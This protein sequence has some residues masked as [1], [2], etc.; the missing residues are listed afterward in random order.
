MR[1]WDY[2]RVSFAHSIRGPAEKVTEGPG[3]LDHFLRPDGVAVVGASTNPSKLGYGIARNLVEGGYP[4]YVAL[5]NAKGGV[6]FD[7]PLYDSI[8]AVPRHVD[9]AVILVPA[10][11]VPEV[12]EEVGTCRIPAAIIASGGFGEQG[13]DGTLLEQRCLAIARRYGIRLLGPNCIGILDTHLPLDTTFL[14][15]PGPPKGEIAFVSQ[16]GA[17]CAIV[18][19]WAKSLDLGISKLISLGNQLDITETDVLGPI[20]RDP[21]SAVVTLYLEGVDDGRRFVRELRSLSQ[22]KP[23]IVLKVGR[24]DDGR[25]AVSSHTGAMAGS[26]AGY[27]AAFRRAGVVRA[28]GLE[29]LFDFARALAWCPPATGSR[30]AVLTNAGGPGITAVD[31]IVGSGLDMARLRPETESKLKAVLPAAASASNPVDMLASATPG[32][33]REC[34]E[35]LVQSSDVDG[36]IIVLPPPPTSRAEDV[37]EA[38]VP[39]IEA[40]QKPVV[41][42]TMGGPLIEEAVRRLRIN[43]I[44]QYASAERAVDA[45]SALTKRARWLSDITSPQGATVT[46]NSGRRTGL[47]EAIESGTVGSAGFL[48]ME[49]GMAILRASGIPIEPLV[50]ADSAATA[51]EAAEKIGFPVVLKTGS[52]DVVHKTDEGGVRLAIP[53]A[54]TLHTAYE[55]MKAQTVYIQRMIPA[56]HDVIVGCIRDSQFGA[57]LMFGSGGTDAEVTSDVAFALAPITAQ[58]VAHLLDNTVAGRKLSSV[59]GRP[60]ADREA[61]IEVLHRMGLLM[62]E[63][64]AIEE[65]EINP[66]RIFEKGSGACAL[67]IRVRVV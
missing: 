44:P 17:V 36:L 19:D 52:P 13:V 18:A 60:Q 43:R 56:G 20:Q 42:A 28:G 15:L 53:D 39:V 50:S 37:V 26:D 3:N 11:L 54:D 47:A 6:L 38:L 10:G 58:D 23:V 2:A 16:S 8:T 35:I 27:E 55:E 45:L 29:Q 30:T 22:K 64:D 57:M 4:G 31:A 21:L 65:I 40:S 25:R 32:Q 24:S 5:V 14:P 49:T 66:L 67:D 1:I 12:L 51:C 63:N 62:A 59:R 33:Y 61:L 48:D 41:V 46:F 9:L 7:R 34:A